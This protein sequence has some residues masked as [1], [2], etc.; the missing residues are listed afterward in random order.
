VKNLGDA[1][2]KIVIGGKDKDIEAFLRDLY[3]KKPPL[4]R[5]DRIEKKEIPP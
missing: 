2:V 4:A 1:G 3:K 5:I